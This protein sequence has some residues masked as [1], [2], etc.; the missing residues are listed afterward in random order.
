MNSLIEP[1]AVS[2]GTSIAAD[3]STENPA[4]SRHAVVTCVSSPVRET[5]PPQTVNQSELAPDTN[6]A[7]LGAVAEDADQPTDLQA[8]A[9]EIDRK[10]VSVVTGP[11]EHMVEPI[12]AFRRSVD[13]CALQAGNLEVMA[14]LNKWAM[15]RILRVVKAELKHGQFEAWLKQHRDELGFGKSSAEN[16]MALAAQYRSAH[17]FLKEDAP[18]RELYNRQHADED[19][20]SCEAATQVEHEQQIER[21]K[22]NHASK[23]EAL[24]KSLTTL[25]KRLRHL[26]ETDE[27]LEADQIRQLKLVKTEIDR[28]FNAIIN[29][30]TATK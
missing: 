21:G 1:I 24:M 17:H 7:R 19:D 28:F 2:D 9:W 12:V 25:Q 26:T 22:L 23:A 29:K 18:L 14:R 16:Y 13:H 15:G 10:I 11:V 5:K 8:A 30:P 20:D 3:R 4:T 6:E 27:Q